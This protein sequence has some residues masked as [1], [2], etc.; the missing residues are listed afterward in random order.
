MQKPRDN[1]HRY[2]YRAVGF[3]G[4]DRYYCRYHCECLNNGHYDDGHD[5]ADLF[6]FCGDPYDYTSICFHCPCNGARA[7]IWTG[8]DT[9]RHVHDGRPL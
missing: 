8:S 6:N 9:R 1:R 7:S 4:H 5:S 2:K 3:S